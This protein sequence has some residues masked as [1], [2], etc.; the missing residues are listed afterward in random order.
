MG[1]GAGEDGRYHSTVKDF[2]TVLI[3][4]RLAGFQERE[5]QKEEQTHAAHPF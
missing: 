3:V 1:A 2:F 4:R 5:Q